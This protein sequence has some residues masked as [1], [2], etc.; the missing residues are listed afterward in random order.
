MLENVGKETCD[1]FFLFHRI[2]TFIWFVHIVILQI[3]FWMPTVS[4]FI[5]GGSKMLQMIIAAMKLKDAYS[6]SGWGTHVNPWL[7]HSNVW[8]NSL[9]IKKKRKKKKKDA[10]SLEG[11]FDQLRQHIKEQRYYFVNKGPSSQG[12]GF[13]SGYV[14]MWE[15]DYKENWAQKNWYFW[16]V[17]SYIWYFYF[18]GG[19]LDSAMAV[20]GPDPFQLQRQSYQWTLRTDLL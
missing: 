4:D 16:T 7:F 3:L 5:F 6:G 2:L 1:C 12:Y 20:K 11:K 18:L 8:Q 10:Y 13:S 9:Q 14:W 17:V 19:C 15:L